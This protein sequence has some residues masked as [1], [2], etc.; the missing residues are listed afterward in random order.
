MKTIHTRPDGTRVCPECGKV[1]TLEYRVQVCC[2]PK[3]RR[4][5]QLRLV[6]A[7]NMRK[8]GK[9]PPL[10]AKCVVCGK[11]FVSTHG[12]I[13][14]SPTC[15]AEHKRRRKRLY[16][17]GRPRDAMPRGVDVKKRNAKLRAIDE[18]YAASTAQIPVKVEN[19]GGVVVERRGNCSGGGWDNRTWQ[20]LRKFG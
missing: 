3:C 18:R 11:E 5:R 20:N 12:R 9:M 10:V 7:N 6:T 14:C 17:K 16:D 15:A 4:A 2:S 13:T 1:F 19:L 8:R